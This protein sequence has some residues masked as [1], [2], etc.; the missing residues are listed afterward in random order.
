MAH[1]ACGCDKKR[2]HQS[3]AHN[4][5][6]KT[7]KKTSTELEQQDKQRATNRKLAT[8]LAEVGKK[9]LQ[10]KYPLSKQNVLSEPKFKGI[11]FPLKQETQRMINREKVNKEVKKIIQDLNKQSKTTKWTKNGDIWQKTKK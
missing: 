6:K 2:K 7:Q 5:N 3:S 9:E 8:Q 4:V 10:Q 11:H 1:Q